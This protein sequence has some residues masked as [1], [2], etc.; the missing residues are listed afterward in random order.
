MSGSINPTPG[1]PR[2][3]TA[4]DGMRLLASVNVVLFHIEYMG[5]LNDMGGG[6]GWLFRLIKGPAFHASLF[7]ILGG[8]IFTTKFAA[9]AAEGSFKPWAFVK[10]RFFELYPL[11]LITTLTMAA[12][13]VIRRW[14][15]D[16]M[17]I[18]KLIYSTLTHLSFLWSFCPIGTISLNTPSWA[19]SAFFLCYI[20]FGPVLKWSLNLKSR[21]AVLLWM[22]IFLVPIAAW[23]CL[24]TSIGLPA[25]Y[26]QF[27]H[28][29]APVRFFEFGLGVLLA[30]LLAI[31][32][33][34]ERP[35]H[36]IFTAAL[37]DALILI[38][39]YLIY[40]N[41]GPHIRITPEIRWFS[42]HVFVIP[43]Y[44]VIIHAVS[45]EKG[46]FARILSL[47]FVQRMGRTS[48]YPYLLHIPLITVTTTF[49]ERVL[50][51]S[52]FLHSP[53]NIIV[54][55]ILLYGASYAYVYAVRNKR[56]AKKAQATAVN[57]TGT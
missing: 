37:C 54:F 25:G 5:G 17:D 22:A 24:F 7:F 36:K 16:T 34:A 46:V 9:N 38:T 45:M 31:Q 40:F 20:L 2:Y 3:F 6:P 56:R 49:C 42:Y 32:G 26:Y 35:R 57:Q 19:L 12:M 1:K 10:K 23:G 15:T 39:L 4:I 55:M 48:F 33:D 21:G 51:Y 30:R 47:R 52:K 13:Y 50:G 14:G 28:G 44:L 29:F 41:L 43:L 53:L 18:P 8:F 27:F 11:H